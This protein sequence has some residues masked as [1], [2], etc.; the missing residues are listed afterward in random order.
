MSIN[1]CINNHTE[2]HDNL[3]YQ[4]GRNSSIPVYL[5]RVRDFLKGKYVVRTSVVARY[6]DISPSLAGHV[7]L[8]HP[9]YED[10]TCGRRSKWIR[11]IADINRPH[12]EYA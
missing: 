6:L 1:V 12:W 3:P 5:D 7:M 11:K 2:K 4:I 8:M 9:N 10:W